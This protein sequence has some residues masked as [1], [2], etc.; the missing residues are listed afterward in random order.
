MPGAITD[1]PK[2]LHSELEASLE[3]LDTGHHDTL[4][5]VATHLVGTGQTEPVI[6]TRLDSLTPTSM[7]MTAFASDSDPGTSTTVDFATPITSI[8][9]LPAKSCLPRPD[10]DPLRRRGCALNSAV[11]HHLSTT[12][13][14]WTLTKGG[15][16]EFD[17][18]DLFE[19]NR[20]D[21]IVS[22]KIFYDTH[23]TREEVGNKYELPQDPA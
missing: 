10:P 11:R 2:Q 19:F 16:I 21:R 7:A 12:P 3:H 8:E 1:F 5:F 17:G 22:M 9:N 20:A 18:V 4:C 13:E 15:Q 23:P 14:D 6:R